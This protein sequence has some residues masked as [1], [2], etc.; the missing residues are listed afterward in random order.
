MG[1]APLNWVLSYKLLL[2]KQK[3][4]HFQHYKNYCDRRKLKN[5]NHSLYVLGICNPNLFLK[6]KTTAVE[7]TRRYRLRRFRQLDYCR[8]IKAAKLFN[9]KKRK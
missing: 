3:T 8:K 5:I 2:W 1:G 7:V 6:K 4:K 9:R